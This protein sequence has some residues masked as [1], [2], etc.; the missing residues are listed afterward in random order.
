MFE[1]ALTNDG[2]HSCLILH[3][4]M[5]KIYIKLLVPWAGWSFAWWNK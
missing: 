5:R 3:Y 4:S 2:D 1:S